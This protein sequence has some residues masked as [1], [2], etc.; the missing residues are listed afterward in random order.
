MSL[1]WLN[2]FSLDDSSRISPFSDPSAA[3]TDLPPSVCSRGQ[4][5]GCGRNIVGWR[6]R[7]D[8]PRRAL[9]AP[10]RRTCS[11]PPGLLPW[12]AGA[13]LMPKVSRGHES[14]TGTLQQSS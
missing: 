2:T 6:R 7:P 10:P 9:D 8:P 5:Q 1:S 11:S 12:F 13:K 14:P 4:D 3:S